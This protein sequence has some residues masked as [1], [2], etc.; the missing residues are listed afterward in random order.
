[1]RD[2]GRVRARGVGGGC[3][4]RESAIF[5]QQQQQRSGNLDTFQVAAAH[6]T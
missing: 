1:M 4:R 3:K 6:V 2:Y 5:Q